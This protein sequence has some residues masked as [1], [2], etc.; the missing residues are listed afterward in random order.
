VGGGGDGP[1]IGILGMEF[2]LRGCIYSTYYYINK[3][4]KAWGDFY[5]GVLRMGSTH[6]VNTQHNM[7]CAG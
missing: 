4:K 1:P 2:P 7:Y 5:L 3:K 6:H